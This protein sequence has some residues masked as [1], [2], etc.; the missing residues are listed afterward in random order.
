MKS[1]YVDVP[2]FHPSLDEFADFQGHEHEEEDL[3]TPCGMVHPHSRRKTAWDLLGM[4]IIIY[5]TITVPQTQ[6][7][8][9]G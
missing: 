7:A 4:V 1:A 3:R 9:A 8:A 5:S 6:A 2:V